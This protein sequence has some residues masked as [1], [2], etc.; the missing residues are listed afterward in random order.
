M[1]STELS[2]LKR[3]LETFTYVSEDL[4]SCWT[5]HRPPSLAS[6]SWPQSVA[7]SLKRGREGVWVATSHLGTH[8][9]QVHFS[10]YVGAMLIPCCKYCQQTCGKGSISCIEKH[11]KVF[12]SLIPWG[13][14]F[15]FWVL[16]HQDFPVLLRHCVFEF[17]KVHFSMTQ[18]SLLTSINFLGLML[19]RGSSSIVQIGRELTMLPRLT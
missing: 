3:F 17:F 13:A 4:G 19:F 11:L 15:F 12:V 14:H 5:T 16:R 1:R 9:S 8:H 2:A 6:D 18:S 7:E 10:I